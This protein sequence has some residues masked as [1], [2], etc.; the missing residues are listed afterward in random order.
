[1]ASIVGGGNMLGA[2]KVDLDPEAKKAAERIDPVFHV[3]YIAPRPLLLMN[4]TRDQLVPRFF[5]E[6]L[7]AAAGEGAKKVWVETD[8]FFS[9]VDRY[10][11]LETV[12]EFMQK[13]LD[14]APQQVAN[15]AKGR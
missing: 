12:I 2:L 3:K 1:M 5:A 15:D 4:V 9:G 6:S 10:K 14:V 8:H 13:G 7:H 11:T